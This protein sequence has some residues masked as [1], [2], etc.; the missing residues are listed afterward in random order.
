[1]LWA[2]IFLLRRLA[3]D[4]FLNLG[5][6]VVG[7][8]DEVSTLSKVGDVDV[9]AV[10]SNELRGG[11]NA[12]AHVDESHI[13]ITGNTR[14]G[15]EHVAGSGVGLELHVD[16]VC[17]R[18][19]AR[20]S[21]E[22]ALEDHVAFDSINVD[23]TDFNTVRSCLDIELDFF[24]IGEDSVDFVASLG[25]DGEADRIA[26]SDGVALTTENFTIVAPELTLLLVVAFP[27]NFMFL[28]V[29]RRTNNHTDHGEAG[30]WVSS[31]WGFFST[32]GIPSPSSIGVTI[33][34]VFVDVALVVS[35]TR[36]FGEIVSGVVTD[37]VGAGFS[38][39][40]VSI[41]SE[42]VANQI[43]MERFEFGLVGE[44][45]TNGIIASLESS[46]AFGSDVGVDVAFLNGVVAST[47]IDTESPPRFASNRVV[48]KEGYEGSTNAR[49]IGNGRSDE[50]DT[51][52]T[53][54][55]GNFITSEISYTIT[56]TGLVPLGLL[57]VVSPR[58]SS[59]NTARGIVVTAI[60]T[61]TIVG[62]DTIVAAPDTS[63][64]R[65]TTVVDDVVG[66]PVDLV[67]DGV[68]SGG[69]TDVVGVVVGGYIGEEVVSTEVGGGEATIFTSCIGGI[70]GVVNITVVVEVHG[71]VIVSKRVDDERAGSFVISDDSAK[72]FL[73]EDGSIFA[74]SHGVNLTSNI[75]L[76][77]D[78]FVNEV[79]N[80]NN[81]DLKILRHQ[82]EETFEI[83][84]G[85]EAEAIVG[86]INDLE[87]IECVEVTTIVVATLINITET[88]SYARLLS[89]SAGKSDSLDTPCVAIG[90]DVDVLYIE[91]NSMPCLAAVETPVDVGCILV[92]LPGNL[93][94][95]YASE[96]RA[97]KV[98]GH[99]ANIGIK[100]V[101]VFT[102]TTPGRIT[103][104]HRSEDESIVSGFGSEDAQ[105]LTNNQ[106]SPAKDGVH[107]LESRSF[108]ISRV[109]DAV[110]SSISAGV[111]MSGDDSTVDQRASGNTAAGEDTT[112]LLGSCELDV[113]VDGVSF[114]ENGTRVARL[115]ESLLG[116]GHASCIV[117]L[118]S[119]FVDSYAFCLSESEASAQ[120]KTNNH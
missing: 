114:C 59:C 27:A 16:A 5:E 8:T 1:M 63:G 12:A 115:G 64:V 4:E 75:G 22:E 15:D 3:D 108:D 71:A 88:E 20:T 24:A 82:L 37:E 99:E 28:D 66:F 120:S 60:G 76:I 35:H 42:T 50:L 112:S 25:L 51:K 43:I 30:S 55:S 83:L 111:A 23:D 89:N 26:S 72:I 86:S 40:E 17:N 113:G 6:L 109:G 33:A 102:I 74:L 77:K 107:L 46:V 11:D 7:D 103:V 94:E 79:G 31:P 96:R 116:S 34:I 73:S 85:S 58:V 19:E 9:G 54:A 87:V 91:L 10:L 2:S 90:V 48:D 14:E 67:A 92:E 45:D 61:V 53:P 110:E 97:C 13:N 21:F 62:E 105:Q 118:A 29:V 41:F 65:L 32:S 38:D 80:P 70:V 81:G 95:G 44:E 119:M 47:R 56:V 52:D 69:V 68:E 101:V 39:A 36:S 49:E 117:V 78:T 84:V 93:I 98:D 57:P 100:V 104:N 106:V 18:I